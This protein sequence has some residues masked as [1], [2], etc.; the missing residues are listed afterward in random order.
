MAS[1]RSSAVWPGEELDALFA[2][3]GPDPGAGLKALLSGGSQSDQC[4]DLGAELDG[5]VL[6]QVAGGDDGLLAIG[7]LVDGQRV[8]DPERIDVP[9]PGELLRDLTLEVRRVEA[10]RQKLY[11]SDSHTRLPPSFAVRRAAPYQRRRSTVP[12][13]GYSTLG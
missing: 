9:E 11:G 3:R 10:D 4:A 1:R 5:L 12:W 13:F 6:A 2:H 7:A 8:D